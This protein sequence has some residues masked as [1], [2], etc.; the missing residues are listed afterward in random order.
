MRQLNWRTK[1]QASEQWS[2]EESLTRL[3][4]ATLNSTNSRRIA[5]AHQRVLSFPIV[6][7]YGELF[8]YIQSLTEYFELEVLIANSRLNLPV[9]SKEIISAVEELNVPKLLSL[10]P[11][12]T[13]EVIFNSLLKIT[14]ALQDSLNNMSR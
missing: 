9:N 14:I 7:V 5:R 11:S 10:F 6:D 4:D 1:L 13:P 8:L 3:I 12:K 2:L